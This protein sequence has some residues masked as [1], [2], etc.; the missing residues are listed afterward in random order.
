MPMRRAEK[1][2]A[3]EWGLTPKRI[4]ALPIDARRYERIQQIWEDYRESQESRDLVQSI[5]HPPA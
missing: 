1:V 2:I 3:R 5:E 4:E